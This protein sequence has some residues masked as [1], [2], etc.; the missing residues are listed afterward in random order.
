MPHKHQRLKDDRSGLVTVEEYVQSEKHIGILYGLHRD[1]L[2]FSVGHHS[3]E[4]QV[5]EL[6]V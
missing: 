1:V 2:T 3:D 5:E 6:Y 4:C